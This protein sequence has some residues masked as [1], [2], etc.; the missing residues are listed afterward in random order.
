ML[1]HVKTQSLA[2]NPTVLTVEN[3]QRRLKLSQFNS[4]K[5]VANTIHIPIGLRDSLYPMFA[6]IILSPLYRELLCETYC[7]FIYTSIRH[8]VAAIVKNNILL[9]RSK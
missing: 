1:K 3:T 2:S 7:L 8:V 4:G 9:L 6:I 5:R